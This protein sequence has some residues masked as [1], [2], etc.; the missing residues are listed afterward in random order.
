MTQKLEVIED[1]T[2]LLDDSKVN[3]PRVVKASVAKD[4]QSLKV[5]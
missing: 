4:D 1:I 3:V 2:S 5:E